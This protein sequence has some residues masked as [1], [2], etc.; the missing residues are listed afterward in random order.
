MND[1]HFISLKQNLE[2]KK[3]DQKDKKG[4]FNF[5]L[6]NNNFSSFIKKKKKKG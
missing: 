1:K 2:I 6:K 5:I 4:I 3:N